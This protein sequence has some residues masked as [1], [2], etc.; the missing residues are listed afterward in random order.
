MEDAIAD[1]DREVM[2]AFGRIYILTR[3]DGSTTNITGILHAG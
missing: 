3:D 2:K 1:L